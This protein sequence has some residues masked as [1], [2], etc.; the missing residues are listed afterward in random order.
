MTAMFQCLEAVEQNNPKLLAQVDTVGVGL[1]K[2][3]KSNISA[4]LVICIQL[5]Y[6]NQFFF[7]TFLFLFDP[8]M[9]VNM[10]S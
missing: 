2:S 5:V 10:T 7:M 8:V 4:F 1:V 6:R 3:V 9:T